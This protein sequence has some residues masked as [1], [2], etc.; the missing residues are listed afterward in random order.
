M[1]EEN[2]RKNRIGISDFNSNNMP[3]SNISPRF[4]NQTMQ[5]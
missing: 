2:A 1:R 4:A 3:D 5:V